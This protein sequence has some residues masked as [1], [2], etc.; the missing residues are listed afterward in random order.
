MRLK[1]EPSSPFPSTLNPLP[2]EKETISNLLE[3]CV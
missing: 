3:T 2:S 1:Y